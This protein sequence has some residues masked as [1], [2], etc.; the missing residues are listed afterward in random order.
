MSVTTL[1]YRVRLGLRTYIVCGEH[2]L[3][4]RSKAEIQGFEVDS[5]TCWGDCELCLPTPS[6]PLEDILDR[7]DAEREPWLK[8]NDH[9]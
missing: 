5:E 6:E 3:R 1:T 4:L 9:E 2:A 8:E 7:Q